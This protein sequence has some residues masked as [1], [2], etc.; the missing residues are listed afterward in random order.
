[1]ARDTVCVTVTPDENGNFIADKSVAELIAAYENGHN[2]VCLVGMEGAFFHISFLTY[3]IEED[4]PTLVFTA[5][6]GGAALSVTMLD[7]LGSDLI[8]FNIVEP[9]IPEFSPQDLTLKIGNYAPLVYNGTEKKSLVI[10]DVKNPYKLTV[11]DLSYDGSVA[12]DITETVNRMIDAKIPEKLPNPPYS[13][14]QRNP[15]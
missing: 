2:L 15:L 9:E 13:D 7:W 6:T 11:N 12:V 3:Y 4:I 8:L 10:P 5:E 14:H 1:M